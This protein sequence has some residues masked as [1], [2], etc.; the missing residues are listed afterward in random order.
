MKLF[1]AHTGHNLVGPKQA[2]R[3]QCYSLLQ[4]LVVLL[5]GNEH[6]HTAAVVELCGSTGARSRRAAYMHSCEGDDGAEE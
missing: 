6:A 1:R 2:R 3:S 4:L 5:N